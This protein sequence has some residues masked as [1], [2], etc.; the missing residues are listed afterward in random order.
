MIKYI[1]LSFVI[2][3]VGA[4]LHPEAKLDFVDYCKYFG[5][6]VEEHVI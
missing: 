3:A 4:E 1:I 2:L 5:Y 6:P